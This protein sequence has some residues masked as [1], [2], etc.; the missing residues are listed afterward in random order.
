MEALEAR[1][2]RINSHLTFFYSMCHDLRVES[3]NIF[4]SAA[5]RQIIQYVLFNCQ[6]LDRSLCVHAT[7]LFFF[8]SFVFAIRGDIAVSVDVVASVFLCSFVWFFFVVACSL[9]YSIISL[10]F[11]SFLLSLLL[12][13]GCVC[14]AN[15]IFFT[16]DC[17]KW[18]WYRDT[19]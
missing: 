18:R 10:F 4:K 3:Y 14:A 7:H 2:V 17:L 6:F 15:T 1:I 5:L 19:K 11:F 9:C 8:L 12:L 13:Y 16:S